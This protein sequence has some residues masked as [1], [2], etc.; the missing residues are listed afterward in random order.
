MVSF[1]YERNAIQHGVRHER[2]HSAHIGAHHAVGMGAGPPWG[3]A[4]R[5]NSSSLLRLCAAADLGR[6]AERKKNARP[7]TCWVSGIGNLYLLP[8]I[9]LPQR[10]QRGQCCLP[11]ISK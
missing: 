2:S 7:A 8:G 5:R 4:V 10:V 11:G 1:P 6:L 3:T 9:T